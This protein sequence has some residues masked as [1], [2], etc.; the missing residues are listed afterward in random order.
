MAELV[1]IAGVGIT[2]PM[3]LKAA[4]MALKAGYDIYM[5]YDDACERREQVGVCLARCQD[6]LKVAS[7][8]KRLSQRSRQDNP[9]ETHDPYMSRRFY[10]NPTHNNL[11][12]DEFASQRL[13]DAITELENACKLSK[14]LAK[15]LEK[16][17]LGWYILFRGT[18]DKKIERITISLNMAVEKFEIKALLANFNLQN[19]IAAAQAEDN[20][21]LELKMEA[22]ADMDVEILRTLREIGQGMGGIQQVMEEV[23]ECK[24]ILEGLS[25]PQRQAEFVRQTTVAVTIATKGRTSVNKITIDMIASAKYAIEIQSIKYNEE[26]CIGE[27]GFGVV[28]KAKWDGTPVAIKRLHEKDA[29]PSS[30]EGHMSILKEVG[31]W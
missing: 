3:V 28:F 14:E 20:K 16:R 26:D 7:E 9:H 6:I 25:L 5:A 12:G 29:A 31:I 22:I 4:G 17:H 11:T 2:V 8:D 23:L 18:T 19:E 1:V 24:K 30:R 10:S 27:G 21:R 13:T 15:D